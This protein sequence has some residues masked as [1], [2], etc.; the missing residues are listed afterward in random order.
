[1]D[2]EELKAGLVPSDTAADA[3]TDGGHADGGEA[4]T[5]IVGPADA[6][7]S[8]AWANCWGELVTAAY[9]FSRS[10]RRVWVD[11]M[12]VN[13]HEPA[14]DLELLRNVIGGV[15]EGLLIV[16]NPHHPLEDTN[17][18]PLRRAWCVF[19]VSFSTRSVQCPLAGF[20]TRE[21]PPPP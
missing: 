20:G 16:I 18:N 6:F 1:M 10:G 14:M 15:P 17:R 8:H 11:C 21:S 4:D 13:Q 19:E 12:A 3:T 7:I 5:A 9:Q 2:E